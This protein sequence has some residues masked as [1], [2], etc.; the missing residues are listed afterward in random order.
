MN[1][2]SLTESTAAASQELSGQACIL[3]E[4]VREYK[5]DENGSELYLTA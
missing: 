2:S 4:M 1:N 5:L 3:L